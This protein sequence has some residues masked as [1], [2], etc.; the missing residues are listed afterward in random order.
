[1][2]SFLFETKGQQS[3]LAPRAFSRSSILQLVFGKQ[4]KL[5]HERLQFQAS[6]PCKPFFL[7]NTRIIN[8]GVYSEV[9]ME[10]IIIN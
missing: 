10:V 4:E 6:I 1:M 3:S 7:R 9:S 2:L 8:P 5:C